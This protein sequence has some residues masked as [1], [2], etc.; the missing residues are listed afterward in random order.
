MC[1][2][3]VPF[4]DVTKIDSFVFDNK[5]CLIVIEDLLEGNA[6]AVVAT[7]RCEVEVLD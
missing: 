1:P 2:D 6:H 3:R 5:C 4:A 7:A